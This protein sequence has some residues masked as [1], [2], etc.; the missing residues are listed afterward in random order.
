[1]YWPIGGEKMKCGD[2]VLTLLLEKERAAYITREIG[3]E[4]IKVRCY[5]IMYINENVT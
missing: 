5:L 1:M 4:N 3:V 2:I